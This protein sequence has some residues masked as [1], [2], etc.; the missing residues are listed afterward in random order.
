VAATD[1]AGPAAPAADRKIT[2]RPVETGTDPAKP[3]VP[4]GSGTEQLAPAITPAAVPATATVAA[5]HQAQPTSPV[6]QLAPALLTLT[7]TADGGQQMTVRLHPADLG[8]VQVRIAQMASGMTQIDI[9]ADNPA[10]LLAL[11]RDQPQLHRTLDDAGMA[12]AGRTVTFHVAQPAQA[13]AGG[14]GSGSPAGNGGGQQG[15]AGRS[16][17]GTT[18]ADGSGGGQGSYPARERT[19]FLTGRRSGAQPAIAGATAATAGKSYRI[20]L[21]I[22]A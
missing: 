14:N 2:L 4:S 5:P 21:D 7:K 6:E 9:T 1:A 11:Q 15:S 12:A 8:M 17:T 19:T 22:T 20:G 3:T 13:A 16:G 18:D 10:T